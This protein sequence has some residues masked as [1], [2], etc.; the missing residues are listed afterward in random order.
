MYLM[1][2]PERHTD[3][4]PSRRE[5]ILEVDWFSPVDAARVCNHRSLRPLMR[6]LRDTLTREW[7]ERA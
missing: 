5:G 7:A 6:A 4:S 1:D 3:F 2:T